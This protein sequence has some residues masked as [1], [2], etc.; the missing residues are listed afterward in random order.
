MFFKL[1]ILTQTNL[2]K[3]KEGKN[4]SSAIDARISE[5]KNTVTHKK[6]IVNNRIELSNIL[7]VLCGGLGGKFY[8]QYLCFCHN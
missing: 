7:P 2:E 3:T 5:L 8:L 1:Q 4:E 6:I